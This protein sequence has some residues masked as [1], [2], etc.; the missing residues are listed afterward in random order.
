MN[1]IGHDT[2]CIDLQVLFNLAIFNT[3]NNNILVDFFGENINPMDYREGYEILIS[4]VPKFIF[5]T[6]S[7]AGWN[8]L[9]IYEIYNHSPSGRLNYRLFYFYGKKYIT[10]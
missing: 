7:F 1:M 10:I 5:S 2:P 9:S 8:V 3:F 4:I 6:H